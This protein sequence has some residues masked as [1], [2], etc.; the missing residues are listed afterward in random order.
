M[1]NSL[2]KL[3]AGSTKQPHNPGLTESFHVTSF[4][5]RPPLATYL[6]NIA[7]GKKSSLTWILTSLVELYE[8]LRSTEQ[9]LFRYIFLAN[10]SSILYG[11]KRSDS[12]RNVIDDTL[13]CLQQTELCLNEAITYRNYLHQELIKLSGPGGLKRNSAK[14][15]K[16]VCEEWANSPCDLSAEWFPKKNLRSGQSGRR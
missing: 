13:S 3:Q 14:T 8:K 2:R 12:L 11:L 6:A 1:R 10:H 7:H 5:R 15:Q 16:Q 4:W 9:D